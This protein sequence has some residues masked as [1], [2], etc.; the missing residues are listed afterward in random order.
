MNLPEIN[1]LREDQSTYI[2]FSKALYDFDYAV[3]NN[4]PCYF[5]KMVAL[6]LPVW[7]NPDFFIDLSSVNVV[8][9]NPNLVIPKTI[10]YYM[11][12]IMRQNIGTNVE[13]IAE[14]AFWKTLNKMGL[15]DTQ[16]RSTV[17]F[18]NSISTSNFTSINNNNGWGEIVCQVPNKCDLLIPAWKTLSNISAT[19]QATDTDNCMFDNGN[20]QFLFSDNLKKV[21]D[22]DNITYNTTD[23]Q[24]F[25]FNVLL[26][27]YTDKTGKQKLHGINF[28][29]PYEDKVTYWDLETFTQKTNKAR[30]IGYQ[31]KFNMKTCNNEATQTAIY[32][33]QE[34]SHFNTF[35]ETLSKLNSFL[36]INT[37]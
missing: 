5:T 22:F 1:S 21:I 14:I 3:N 25:K 17:T 34:N 13:E 19:V 33:L 15:T 9:T 37:K 20:K 7:K 18:I 30:T 31:F 8:S 12:N 23:E 4:T 16:I 27:F 35:F 36:E 28:I 26:L 24:E 10:Q 29:Y 6:N 32:E 11:E 2:T